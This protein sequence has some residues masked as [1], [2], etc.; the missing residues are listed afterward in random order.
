MSEAGSRVTAHAHLRAERVREL[1]VVTVEALAAIDGSYHV[2][3]CWGP[4]GSRYM[5]PEEWQRAARTG[6]LLHAFIRPFHLTEQR[7]GPEH[8]GRDII[9]TGHLGRVKEIPTGGDSPDF[10]EARGVQT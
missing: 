9:D 4:H 10:N 7:T 3:P 5:H 1:G 8:S 2:R 6:A